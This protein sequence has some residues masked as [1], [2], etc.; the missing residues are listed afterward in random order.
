MKEGYIGRDGRIMSTTLTEFYSIN[1]CPRY[2]L[3]YSLK[4]DTL[5]YNDTVALKSDFIIPTLKLAFDIFK[6]GIFRVNIYDVE[7]STNGDICGYT[8]DD[9][10]DL[11]EFC[12]IFNITDINEKRELKKLIMEYQLL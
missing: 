6:Q 8:I 5:Y 2:V 12:T 11:D 9:N 4:R 7:L 1:I 3:V 10:L